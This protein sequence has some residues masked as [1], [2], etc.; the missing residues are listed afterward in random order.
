MPHENGEG[1]KILIEAQARYSDLSRRLGPTG[2]TF[3]ALEIRLR[4]AVLQELNVRLR[5][6]LPFLDFAQLGWEDEAKKSS[7]GEMANENSFSSQGAAARIDSISMSIGSKI[8]SLRGLIFQDT[9]A[10]LWSKAI[11]YTIANPPSIMEGTAFGMSSDSGLSSDPSAEDRPHLTIDR[12]LAANVWETHRKI[13]NHEIVS[14]EGG[15]GSGQVGNSASED[16]VGTPSSEASSSHDYFSV[17]G[18][19]FEQARSQ[20]NNAACWQLRSLPPKDKVLTHMAFEVKLKGEMDDGGPGGPYREFFASVAQELQASLGGLAL[21]MPSRAYEATYRNNGSHASGSTQ[22][23]FVLNP[24]SSSPAHLRQFEFLG[25]LIGCALRTHVLMPLELPR[26]FWKYLVG[27]VPDRTDLCEVDGES[28]EA[29]LR[30]IE[31]CKTPLE[32]DVFV[33]QTLGHERPLGV[34]SLASAQQSLDEENMPTG[35]PWT[36]TRS[37]GVEIDLRSFGGPLQPS[38]AAA[39]ESENGGTDSPNE[40]FPEHIFTGVSFAQRHEFV[41][42]FET[43]R[44]S[45]SNTQLQALARGLQRMVPSQLLR[46][47]TEREFQRMV[48]GRSLIDLSLL[49]R[50]TTLDSKIDKDAPH[51]RQFWSVLET[52]TQEDLKKFIQFTYAQRRLPA[53]DEE[54]RLSRTANMRIMP[55]KMPKNRKDAQNRR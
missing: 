2:V 19:L 51:I 7:Q 16:G 42:R 36:C 20:L 4:V 9:K 25:I 45:E 26:L 11:L 35:L 1:K 10:K 22:R 8:S 53:S 13:E 49:K 43:C 30:N 17:D 18:T 14:S 46:L 40:P 21:L 50:H 15:S 47:F 27:I 3:S 5:R 48:C 28:V 23:C 31:N 32:F 37:D 39:S 55:A 12:G 33:H 34:N 52:F 38:L 44:L 41:R 29:F 6:I 54:W 24:G